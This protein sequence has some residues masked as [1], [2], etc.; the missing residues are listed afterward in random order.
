MEQSQRKM[1]GRAAFTVSMGAFLFFQTMSRPSMASIHT[2][3]II[4]L[5]ACGML[6]GMALYQVIETFRKP[7]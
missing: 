1:A 5:V 3:D 7:K 4:R 6:L 2:V